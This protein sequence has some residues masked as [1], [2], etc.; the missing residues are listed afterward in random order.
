M[1]EFKTAT[2][3]ASSDNPEVLEPIEFTID[4]TKVRAYPPS[5]GQLAMMFTAMG[6][7]ASEGRQV[8]GII[9]FFFGLLDED[10][11][12]DLGRRLMD[13][14]DNF[15]LEQLIEIM[16]WLMEEFAGR[17]TRPPSDSS[18]LPTP[19]GPKSTASAR[20]GASTRSRSASTVSAT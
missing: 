15:E 16:S 3:A 10:S 13:R 18:Q 19:I 4:D 2:K 17:P 20:N 5:P 1:K 6:E 8:S 12:K 14:T 9:D 7:Y 11:H